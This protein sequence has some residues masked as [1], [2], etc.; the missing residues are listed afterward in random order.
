MSEN[1][2]KID[3][4]GNNQLG[5]I[6]T[7]LIDSTG[8]E[9]ADF[10]RKINVGYSTVYSMM[11]GVNNSPRVFTL[12]PIAQ[13][14]DISLEQLIGVEELNK[15]RKTKSVQIETNKK[16]TVWDSKLFNQSAGLASKVLTKRDGKIGI[17]QYLEIVKEVYMYTVTKKLSKPDANFT[18]WFC[19]HHLGY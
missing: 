17:D 5:S 9:L 18:E 13:F 8:M 19:K 2:Q 10:C 15:E 11:N 16:N 3:N 1:A 7:K 12:L 6:L 14:F 4:S